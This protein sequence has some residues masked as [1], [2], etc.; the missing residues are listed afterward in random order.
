MMRRFPFALALFREVIRLYPPVPLVTRSLAE[1]QEIGGRTFPEG[2]RVTFPRLHFGRDSERY[3][4]PR[5]FD[6]DRWTGS[7]VAPGSSETIAFGAGRT[8]ASGITSLPSRSSRSRSRSRCS[9]P[10]LAA[11][12]GSAEGP[13]ATYGFLSQRRRRPSSVSAAGL[14]EVLADPRSSPRAS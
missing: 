3:P 4:N 2:T 12:L 11:A 7:E 1:A 8:S 9:R 14:R 5:S 13:R 10:R 6:A